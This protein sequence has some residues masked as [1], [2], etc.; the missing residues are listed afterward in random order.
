MRASRIDQL[1]QYITEH[2][3]VTLDSLCE[4]FQ[5]SKNTVR[6]D[7]EVL[8]SRGTAQKV[9][10]GVV[11]CEGSRSLPALVAFEERAGKNAL[12]KQKIAALAASFVK[13]QDVIFIDSGSTTMYLVDHLSHINQVTVLTNSLQVINRAMVYPNLSLIALPGTLKRNTA[14]LVGSSCVEYLEHYN[15]GKAFMACTGL[16]L[17]SGVCNASTEEYN[18]KKM[19]MKK[20]QKRYLLAD[21]S[22]FGITSLM[23]FG[24]IREFDKILTEKTPEKRFC[25]FCQEEGCPVLTAPD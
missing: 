12:G 11:A 24:E 1:E 6:R 15:I 25:S 8:V 2:K 9:Y 14:S 19:A 17:Q 13:D 18:V 22:K 21:S 10:G 20:S 23:T 5:V 16:S 4:A 7:L 3:S